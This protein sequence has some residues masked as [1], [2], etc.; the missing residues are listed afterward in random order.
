MS[1]ENCWKNLLTEDAFKYAKYRVNNRQE[2]E[3]IE[4]DRLYNNLLSADEEQS[5]INGNTPLTQ[6]YRNFLLSEMYGYI[7]GLLSYSII[8]APKDHPSTKREVESLTNG[9]C[10]EYKNNIH[11]KRKV[12]FGGEAEAYTYGTDRCHCSCDDEQCLFE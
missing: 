8:L 1:K 6:I 3:T 9:L 2:R 7:K 10:K 4:S 12:C 5:I 11:R